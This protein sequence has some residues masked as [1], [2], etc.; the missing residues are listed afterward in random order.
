MDFGMSKV[1]CIPC[2][3]L[4]TAYDYTIIRHSNAKCSQC[5]SKKQGLLIENLRPKFKECTHEMG[6]SDV[7]IK[8]GCPHPSC[9]KLVKKT[10]IK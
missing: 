1:I 9:K 5:G 8:Y 6:C 4:H 3:N 7:K 10:L 2:L